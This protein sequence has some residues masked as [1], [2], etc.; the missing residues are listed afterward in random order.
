MKKL[1]KAI[2]VYLLYSVEYKLPQLRYG[3]QD[4]RIKFVFHPITWRIK[5]LIVLLS[6]PIILFGGIQALKVCW[7]DSLQKI[8]S[9]RYEFIVTSIYDE[10]HYSKWK[11][12]L[13]F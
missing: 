8:S 13:K 1:S 10:F 2:L 11:A 9:Q 5:L 3:G 4:Y 7:R 6:L 12:C